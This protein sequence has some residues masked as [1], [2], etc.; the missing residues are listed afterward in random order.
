MNFPANYRMDARSLA[1]R[2]SSVLASSPCPANSVTAHTSQLPNEVKG[3]PAKIAERIRWSL[4]NK[5][6][7][8]AD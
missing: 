2:F 5:T 4:R 7:R 6:S 8:R 3:A 1:A